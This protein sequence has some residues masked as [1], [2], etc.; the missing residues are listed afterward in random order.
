MTTKLF[1]LIVFQEHYFSQEILI[2]YYQDK[3][4]STI[5]FPKKR[6]LILL[7]YIHP[8]KL[9]PL[10]Q[11]LLIRKFKKESAD[12]SWHYLWYSYIAGR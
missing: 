11:R 1:V 2:T 8:L 9:K 6:K 4:K 5:K 10:F 7:W 3:K 12:I